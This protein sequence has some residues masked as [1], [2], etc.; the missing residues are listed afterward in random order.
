MR[1]HRRQY[2][3]SI[4]DLRFGL[5]KERHHVVA[6]P[7]GVGPRCLSR[8]VFLLLDGTVAAVAAVLRRDGSVRSRPVLLSGPDFGAVRRSDGWH[9]QRPET[10]TV[11]NTGDMPQPVRGRMN[12]GN[13]AEFAQTNDCPSMIAVGASCTF[14]ITFRPSATGWR[15]ASLLVDGINEEEGGVNLGGHGN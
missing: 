4:L 11:N 10:V 15:G 7:D 13:S 2:K 5:R 12:G 14:N 1:G 6:T 8:C 9:N 3:S